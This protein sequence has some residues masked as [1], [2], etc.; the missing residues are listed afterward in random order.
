M[1]G[2]AGKIDTIVALSPR[3]DLG[4]Q[5]RPVTELK[6]PDLLLGVIAWR[7]SAVGRSKI[8]DS[9]VH[10]G[11]LPLVDQLQAGPKR[12]SGPGRTADLVAVMVNDP[13]PG[14]LAAISSL[15]RKTASNSWLSVGPETGNRSISKP[16][17][18]S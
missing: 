17:S 13:A 3:L 12:D 16:W 1:S 2:V 10:G 7:K 5:V 14:N 6:V 8:A 4:E 11:E 18:K 9:E 15:R